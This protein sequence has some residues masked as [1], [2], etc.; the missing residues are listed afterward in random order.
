MPRVTNPVQSPRMGSISSGPAQ[1]PPRMQ[2]QR[3][4]QDDTEEK[5]KEK[6]CG[7]CIVM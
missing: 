3:L 2:V 4:D 1:P 6:S 7:C 5:V